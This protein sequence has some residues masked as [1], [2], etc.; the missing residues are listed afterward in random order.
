AAVPASIMYKEMKALLINPLDSI[1]LI[2]YPTNR[3]PY[4]LLYIESYLLTKGV[5]AFYLDI[6]NQ[7]ISRTRLKD[8]IARI[9]ADYYVINT[10]GKNYHFQYFPRTDKHIKDIIRC[11][12]D[13]KPGALVM[14][15]GQSS[16]VY[17]ERY[18]GFD[19]DCIIYDEPEYSAFEIID[20]G[21]KKPS[22]LKEIKGIHYKGNGGFIKNLP[23]DAMQTLDELPPPR[24]ENLGGHFWDS[25]Y[26]EREGFIDIMGMRGCPYS[27]K[28][29]KSSLSRKVLFHS[30]GYLLEQI[31]VLNRN[32]N[33]TDFFIRDSG[34]FDDD[35]RCRELCE[36]LR[37]IKGIIWKCNARVDNMALDKLKVMKE[38]GCSLISYGVES[39]NEETLKAY[40]KGISKENVMNTVA[41][42]RQAGIKVAT[43][44]IIGFPE[45]GCG[46]KIKSLFFA[47][48]LS[49][50]ILY[51]SKY[52]SLG[53]ERFRR[54]WRKSAR[55]ILDMFLVA[56]FFLGRKR[57]IT[58]YHKMRV[59]R[60]E[61]NLKYFRINK[62][63]IRW[64]KE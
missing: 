33:Y 13:H 15:Y 32:Y 3:P 6:E 21:I 9:K 53:T 22:G 1:P 38:A 4:D 12:R 14:L 61:Y 42:T 10:T 37:Q 20:R 30:P 27:C 7:G 64:Q 31:K 36:G 2:M 44:F 43:Y 60:I 5:S 17:T 8:H 62:Q 45:E 57:F 58:Y 59:D 51:I 63:K 39:G 54:S 40:N 29:C 41:R 56:L 46:Q 19:V 34:Y 23:R 11:I 28:F 47:R 49:P 48:A 18:F 24:W 55:A 52:Y 50:D 25:T 26:R 16:N 35:S